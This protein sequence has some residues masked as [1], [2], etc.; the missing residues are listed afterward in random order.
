MRT[1]P[2]HLFLLRYSFWTPLQTNPKTGIGDAAENEQCMSQAE[3]KRQVKYWTHLKGEV[4]AEQWEHSHAATG[5][6]VCSGY[7]V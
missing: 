3:Y 2:P 7:D 1:F 4:S 5:L 6:A